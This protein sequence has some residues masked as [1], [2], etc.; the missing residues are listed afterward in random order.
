VVETARSEDA[1]GLS[2]ILRE[3]DEFKEALNSV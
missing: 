2:T 3:F 1:E